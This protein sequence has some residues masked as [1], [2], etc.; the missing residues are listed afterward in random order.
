M[1]TLT[2]EFSD[3]KHVTAILESWRKKK[4]IEIRDI[5]AGHTVIHV[6]PRLTLRQNVVIRGEFLSIPTE[7][8]RT[9]S[10]AGCAL[11]LECPAIRPYSTAGRVDGLHPPVIA[12]R[13]IQ[14]RYRDAILTGAD[15]PA[16]GEVVI[17]V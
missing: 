11:C 10:A 6:F 9:T 15:V 14:P 4:F 17:E 1:R 16:V 8:K 5:L 7:N 13:I 2:F 12:C 3:R